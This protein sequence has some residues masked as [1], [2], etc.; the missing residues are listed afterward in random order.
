MP[1]NGL[2]VRMSDDYTELLSCLAIDMISI[3][4]AKAREAFHEQTAQ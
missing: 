1:G 3:F 4:Q 2:R